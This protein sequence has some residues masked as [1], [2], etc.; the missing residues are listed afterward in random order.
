MRNLGLAILAVVLAGAGSARA[1]Q[2]S[3]T[4]NISGTPDLRVE[5][6]DANIRVDTWDQKTIEATIVSS[7]YKV[8]PGGL[9]VQEQ[10]SGDAV[11]IDV[12]FPHEFHM[13]N[14]SHRV[15]INIH[16]P[17]QGRVSLHT[18]DGKI[19]LADFRGEMQLNSG[20]GGEEIH[21]VE[22]R[23]HAETGD[24]HINADGRFD[25]LN[26]K[27]GDGHLDVR[28]AAGSTLAEEWALHTGDGSVTVELPEN[29]AA[30]LYLHNGDG[31][32]DVDLP[33]TT[34][35]RLKGNELRGKLNGGGKLI[36]VHTGDGSI[37]L[38]KG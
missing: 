35:G 23:L 32:I 17:R 9:Q 28:V 36:T 10:Q 3:K 11:E 37:N 15:D 20:D 18:G 25:A 38:R 16:M 19:E 2:W 21:H 27:S 12:R 22:G 13:V 8:G 6:T 4:Y 14:F 29:L 24:G 30:D 33:M 31:N 5:T 7:H 26:L 34:E 1:E